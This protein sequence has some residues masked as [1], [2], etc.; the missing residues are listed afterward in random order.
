MTGPVP[1]GSGGDGRTEQWVFEAV[2]D[3]GQLAV[4]VAVGRQR[5]AG[6]AWYRAVLAGVGRRPVVVV[7]P[8]IGLPARPASLELRSPGLWCDHAPD[9]PPEAASHWTVAAEAF[10]VAVDDPYEVWG[11]GFGDRTPVGL[12]LSFDPQP[13]AVGGPW[14]VTGCA[15]VGEVLVA[16]E[17]HEVAG[18]GVVGVDTAAGPEPSPGSWRHWE[19]TGPASWVTAAGTSAS[20]P[21]A[22]ARGWVGV[23]DGWGGPLAVG[24]TSDDEVLG[25]ATWRPRQGGDR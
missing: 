22:P 13:V 11:R 24:P 18:V 2:F 1:V 5:A 9:G 12:D 20:P 21:A 17:R 15:V 10:G 8:D 16:D 14:R 19:A 3:G 6:R 25:W 7:D 23:V 4:S